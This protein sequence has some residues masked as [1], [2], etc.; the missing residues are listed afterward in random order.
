GAQI[1][2]NICFYLG[3]FTDVR[4]YH[5]SVFSLWDPAYRAFAP[6]AEDPYVGAVIHFSRTLVCLGDLDEARLR[7]D[8]ALAE[9]QRLSPFMRAFVLRQAWYRDWA[10]EGTEAGRSML[11]SAKEVVTVSDEHGFRDSLAIGN[12][13]RGWCLASLG[14]AAEGIPLLLGGLATC[15]AGNRKLMIPFFC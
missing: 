5:E 14:Q 9:S 6:T 3:K 11:A 8:E 15:R 2:G 4:A 7:R 1:S 12:I 10:V 13:M